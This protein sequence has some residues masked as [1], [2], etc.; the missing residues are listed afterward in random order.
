MD[1]DL[2]VPMASVSKTIEV[3]SLLEKIE[4]QYITGGEKLQ[5][6]IIKKKAEETGKEIKKRP[7]MEAQRG[8]TWETWRASNYITSVM[9]HKH[10]PEIMLY[11]ED[12]RSQYQKTLDGQQRL[13]TLWMFVNNQFALNMKK[14][15]FNKFILDGKEYSLKDLNGKK[16]SDLPTEWQDRI[17]SYPQ[18]ITIYNSCSDRQAEDL[19]TEMANGTKPLKPV[20]IRKAAM[21]IDVRKFIYQLLGDGWAFHTMTPL[22]AIG[23]M[24]IDIC[25]QFLTL[26][27]KGGPVQLD[28]EIVDSLIY[29]FRDFGIPN[30]VKQ[31]ALETSQY[32][33]NATDTMIENKKNSDEGIKKGRK[34]KNYNRFRFPIFKNK[35]YI[36]MFLW[37]GYRAKTDNID[38]NK[39]AEW[40]IKFFTDPSDLFKMGIG[41]GRNKSNDLA[42]VSKRMNAIDI[43]IENLK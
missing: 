36:L 24:G 33:T 20:E 43:E 23:N 19:Y 35:T 26:L 3:S 15:N 25:S 39:F 13:T 18:E 11:R 12:D 29:D 6:L 2:L 40:T 34:I 28:K 27:S 38:I 7:Y 37:A 41:T 1:T 8:Y 22:S 30:D 42:N 4:K 16:F 5:D 32:L 31:N 10:I 21:G 17:L 14:A 9:F